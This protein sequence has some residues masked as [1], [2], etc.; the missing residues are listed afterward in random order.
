MNTNRILLDRIHHMDI[1]NLMIKINE[2]PQKLKES[3]KEN[4]KLQKKYNKLEENRIKIQEQT[5]ILEAEIKRAEEEETKIQDELKVAKQ[6]I[7]YRFCEERII[8]VDI[9]YMS[10][11]KQEVFDDFTHWFTK[12]HGNNRPK[13]QELYEFLN[14]K[15]GAYKKK[16]WWGYK[17]SYGNVEP[18]VYANII[19]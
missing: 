5:A 7:F 19:E 9:E 18:I 12:N 14:K 16:G 2:Q 8:K 15:I 6:E 17:I 13:G 10:I 4:K 11:G 3:K 1:N